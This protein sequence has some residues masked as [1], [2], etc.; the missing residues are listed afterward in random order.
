MARR[1]VCGMV[2]AH[3]VLAWLNAEQ[4]LELDDGFSEKGDLFAAGLDSM[5]VMQLVVL[6]EEKYGV[7]L[8]PAD[9][10][11]E[12]LSTPIALAELINRKQS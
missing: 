10:N 5:A 1:S 4:L 12:N 2:S 3:E 9:I 6:A 7:V 11:R 8:G